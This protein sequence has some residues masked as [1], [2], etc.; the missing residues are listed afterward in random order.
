[1]LEQIPKPSHSSYSSSI[2]PVVT[3]IQLLFILNIMLHST[4]N[5][6]AILIMGGCWRLRPPMQH[7]THSQWMAKKMR[8]NSSLNVVREYAIL[9]FIFNSESEMKSFSVVFVWEWKVGK[10]W[11]LHKINDLST[12]DEPKDMPNLVL[13]RIVCSYT[14]W[15]ILSSCCSEFSWQW[16]WAGPDFHTTWGGWIGEWRKEDFCGILRI[17]TVHTAQDDAYH[18]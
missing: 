17:R 10:N 12:N 4:W 9:N 6:T 1:M 15:F 2:H 13:C 14:Y 7:H 5:G 8:F 18:I 11:Y 16:N 3:T